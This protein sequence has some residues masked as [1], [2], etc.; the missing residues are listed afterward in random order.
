MCWRIMS[1]GS[2]NKQKFNIIVCVKNHNAKEHY[3]LKRWKAEAK[4][5]NGWKFE[6]LQFLIQ[7]LGLT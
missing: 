5:W 3:K 4:M 2:T 1:G 6:K 7:V